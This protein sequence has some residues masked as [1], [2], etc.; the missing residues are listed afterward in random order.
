MVTSKAE[1]PHSSPD[2]DK[3]QMRLGAL[4]QLGST[5]TTG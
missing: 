4:S 1:F 3:G 5:G 2:G